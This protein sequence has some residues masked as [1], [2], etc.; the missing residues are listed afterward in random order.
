[1]EGK[2]GNALKYGLVG[3]SLTEKLCCSTGL[4]RCLGFFT[5]HG[6][7]TERSLVYQLFFIRLHSVRFVHLLRENMHVDSYVRFIVTEEYCRRS[8]IKRAERSL[9]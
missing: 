9:F 2:D 8:Q 1:M 4:D 5:A 6:L 7:S 3:R